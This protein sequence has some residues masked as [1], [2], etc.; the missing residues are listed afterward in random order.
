MK[1]YLI[2]DNNVDPKPIID[3]LTKKTQFEIIS[4]TED[5]IPDKNGEQNI[6][7]YLYSSEHVSEESLQDLEYKHDIQI[8]AATVDPATISEIIVNLLV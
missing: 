3:L 5:N 8:D 1:I 2:H 6:T 4:T 7:V